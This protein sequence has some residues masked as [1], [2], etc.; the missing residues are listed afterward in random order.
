MLNGGVLV[1]RQCGDPEQ[2]F[3][4]RYWAFQSA[5]SNPRAVPKG[6]AFFFSRNR[7]R[8]STEPLMTDLISLAAVVILFR[9]AMVYIAGCDR[10]KGNR[11]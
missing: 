5:A 3:A 10:L 11:P 8:H 1:C 4:C 7:Y 2:R 9:T 6:T